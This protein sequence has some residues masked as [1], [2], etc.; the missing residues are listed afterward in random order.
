[1][2]PMRIALWTMLT[3]AMLIPGSSAPANAQ[4]REFGWGIYGGRGEAYENGYRRGYE[5][6][7]ADARSRRPSDVRREREYRSA[8]RGY[9]RRFGSRDDYRR[10]FRSGFEAGYGDGYRG[11]GWSEQRRQLPPVAGYPYPGRRDD[12][13]RNGGY[14]ANAW[15]RSSQVA[16]NYGYNDGYE[17][18]MKAARDRR[19]FDPNR[20]G[21]YRDG[22]R[23]Y[24]SDYG[25]RD[26][27]RTAYRDGFLRGYE[28]GYGGNRFGW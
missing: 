25:P 12:G 2:K 19:P 7:A 10:M 11:R 8:D 14:G 17:R 23:H 5:S 27:Y 13:D 16:F 21:W 22:D 1:M 4:V 9:D 24:D 18:G 28:Q 3:A 15:G 6:G 26:L 20:E